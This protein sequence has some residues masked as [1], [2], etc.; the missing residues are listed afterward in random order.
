MRRVVLLVLTVLLAAVG[1]AAPARAA[2]PDVWAFAGV[3]NPT[4]APG[5]VLPTQFAA[6]RCPSRHATVRETSTG[7]YQVTLPCSASTRGIVHVTT[8]DTF[9]RFCTPSRWVASNGNEIVTVYCY[10]QLGLPNHATFTVLY[11]TSSGLASPG[12]YAYVHVSAAGALIASDNSAGATNTVTRLGVGT[13][14]VRLPNRTSDKF[15]GDLQVTAVDPNHVARHCKVGAWDSGTG[16]NLVTVRCFGADRT[17]VDS[18]FTL[19]YHD[20]RAVYGGVPAHFGYLWT[21]AGAPPGSGFNS[22][23]ATNGKQANTVFFPGIGTGATTVQVTPYGSGP[24]YCQPTQWWQAGG[25][26]I[27][28]DVLCYAAPSQ[29]AAI[30]PYFITA[31]SST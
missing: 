8:V 3:T 1:L 31:A 18:P 28:K 30:V 27:V 10:G 20:R 13:Y 5:S 11:T 25:S 29:P 4:P 26:I 7:V 9:G 23:G 15:A 6:S 21:L 14:Q 19:S 17:Q 16:L 24:T 12:S 2:T 22:T